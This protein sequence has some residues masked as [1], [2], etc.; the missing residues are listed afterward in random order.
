MELERTDRVFSPAEVEQIFGVPETTQRD[1]RRHGHLDEA[2][3]L[4]TFPAARRGVRTVFSLTDAGILGMAF[5]MSINSRV[6][7]ERALR[8]AAIA[9][10]HLEMQL[11][12]HPLA[13]RY[14]GWSP[15]REERIAILRPEDSSADCDFARYVLVP[16][17][18]PKPVALMEGEPGADVYIAPSLADFADMAVPDFFS[19]WLLD[20]GV[21]ASSVAIAAKGPVITWTVVEGGS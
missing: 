18:V 20:L 15:T 3:G 19:S 6:P 8:I 16:H 10:P 1:W 12:L 4:H 21:F 7:V 13:T 11:E 9:W 5:A 2:G 17:K 14:V